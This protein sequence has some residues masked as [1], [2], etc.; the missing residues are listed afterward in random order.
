[1]PVVRAARRALPAALLL[2][3]ALPAGA[4]GAATMS[5]NGSTL[6]F[7]ASDGLDHQTYPFRASNGHLRIDDVDG[8][9]VGASGCT[10]VS[11][12]SVDCGPASGYT[13]VVFV[14]GT[15]DDTV[16]TD[17]GLH[18]PVTVDGAGG[19]DE[20]DGGDQADVLDGGDGADTVYGNGGADVV[21]GGPG[22][23]EI[24]GG[25]GIDTIDGGAGSDAVGAWD[26]AADVAPVTCGIGRR[27]RRLRLQPGH[28][29]L[30]LRDP[31]AAHRG[32]GGD[33]R[34]AHRRH[35]PH[36]LDAGDDR[37]HTHRLVHVLG[38]L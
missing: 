20:I 17:Y 4:Q 2:A 38:A 34:S 21:R 1:M 33:L 19:N 30:G 10:S 9:S 26:E 6:S 5:V 25:T 14:F 7:T 29:R 3:L 18:L 36:P 16:A 32:P 28:H 12:G 27:H 23:D 22:D 15:G 31:P 37:R 35:D 24:S 11:P 13:R 8:I